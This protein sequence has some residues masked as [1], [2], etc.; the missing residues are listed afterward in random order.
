MKNINTNHVSFKSIILFALALVLGL[1]AA[2]VAAVANEPVPPAIS[3]LPPQVTQNATTAIFYFYGVLDA[4]QAAES[5]E[6]IHS[7]RFVALINRMQATL[8]AHSPVMFSYLWGRADGF[9]RAAD[10]AGEPR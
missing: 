6:L 10:R 7:L 4:E 8:F 5:P 9:D 2:P 1:V 3:E